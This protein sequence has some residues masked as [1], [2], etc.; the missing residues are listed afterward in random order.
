MKPREY[1]SLIPMQASPFFQI[2]MAFGKYLGKYLGKYPCSCSS[3]LLNSYSLCRMRPSKKL[4]TINH[5][6]V[7]VHLA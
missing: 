1:T 5:L 4:V 2:S 3:L 7:T 6:V